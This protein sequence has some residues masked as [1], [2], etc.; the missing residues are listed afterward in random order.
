MP[1]SYYLLFPWF[2]ISIMCFTYIIHRWNININNI[3]NNNNIQGVHVVEFIHEIIELEIVEPIDKNCCICLDNLIELES[4][5][6][7]IKTKCNHYYH[8]NCIKGWLQSDN[9]LNLNCPLCLTHL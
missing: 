1:S 3:N 8:R 2:I 7:V 6:R 9:E 5:Q 4:Q